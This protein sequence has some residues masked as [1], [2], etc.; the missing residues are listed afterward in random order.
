[1]E[2]EGALGL[3]RTRFKR[4]ICWNETKQ[5]KNLHSLNNSVG[6][7]TGSAEGLVE[8]GVYAAKATASIIMASNSTGVSFPSRRCRRLR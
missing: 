7:G 5:S 8:S 4:R 3:M 2:R 1:M 6:N